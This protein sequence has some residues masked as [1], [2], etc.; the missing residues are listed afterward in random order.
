VKFKVEKQDETVECGI[1]A[2]YV[3]D[4]ID[5]VIF[6]FT[7]NVSGR[8]KPASDGRNRSIQNQPL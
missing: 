8:S 1:S 4:P 6:N 5:M 7:D 3:S 2:R